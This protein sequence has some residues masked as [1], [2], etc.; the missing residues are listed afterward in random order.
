MRI[1]SFMFHHNRYIRAISSNESRR[2]RRRR[3]KISIEA[4]FHVDF[5]TPSYPSRPSKD[6]HE[7]I[8]IYQPHKQRVYK[9]HRANSFTYTT[10]DVQSV[11]FIRNLAKIRRK[12][13]IFGPIIITRPR[14][15]SL[16]F[17]YSTFPRVGGS[18]SP[19]SHSE[20][21]QRR[22]WWLVISVVVSK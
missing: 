2:S 3:V 10:F 12:V 1:I 19:S 20:F 21:I 16:D 5:L 6:T 17:G 18:V 7:Y 14:S 9:I 4:L 15:S 22:W 8:Y 13:A 11:A